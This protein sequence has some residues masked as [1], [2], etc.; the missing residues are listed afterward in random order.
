MS[1]AAL[2]ENVGFPKCQPLFSV[3]LDIIP[4]TRAFD[5]LFAHF[6]IFEYPGDT[7]KKYMAGR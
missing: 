5:F 4:R 2:S 7:Q 1:A 3:R 6:S